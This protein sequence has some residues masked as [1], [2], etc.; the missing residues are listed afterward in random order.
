M[1]SDKQDIINVITK[2]Q[3]SLLFQ[4]PNCAIENCENYT[5][6]TGKR[7]LIPST[8]DK[9]QTNVTLPEEEEYTR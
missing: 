9:K 6:F 7:L 1:I 2:Y 8:L 3:L 4:V 5:D